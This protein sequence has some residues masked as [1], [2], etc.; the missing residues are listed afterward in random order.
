MF[1]V[2]VKDYGKV[3]AQPGE[4]YENLIRQM[5]LANKPKVLAVRCSNVLRELNDTIEQPCDLTLVDLA[6]SDGEKIYQRSLSFIM[7]Y[8][9]K[10]CFPNIKVR[11]EHSLSKGLYCEFD[12]ERK[13]LQADYD[14]IR[15]K[16]REAIEADLPFEKMTVR[17]EEAIAIFEKRQ[18]P[19]KVALLKYRDNDWINLYKLED[20][21]DYFYGYMVPST[22]YIQHFEIVKYDEGIILMH[23]TKYHPFGVAPFEES[24]M[25]AEVFK[26]S[27]AWGEIMNI[28]YVCNLNALIESGEHKELMQIAEALHEKK[29]ATIADIITKRRKRVI[30]IAGPSSSGKTTFANRLRLQLKVNGLHPITISTDNYFVDRELTPRDENGDLDFESLEAVDVDLFNKHIMQLLDGESVD[31]PIFD[32]HTG[33]RTYRQKPICINAQQ[34]IIIEGIHGLNE[35]LSYHIYKRDKFKIYVS[36]LTQLNIDEHNRIPTTQTRLLRRIVRDNQFRGHSA[37]KTINMW[38]SVRRGE[39]KNI[40]PFQEE[41]DIMFNTALPYELAIL[42]KHAEPL[43]AQIPQSEPAYVEALLLM[44]FLSYFKS[45]EDDQLVPYVSILKEFIGGSGF[46]V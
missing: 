5:A 18:M 32:F 4:R 31:L 9:A 41:A 46:D 37:L 36:A 6:S 33:K 23:P 30:L 26:E 15:L 2:N 34:P 10:V 27:E 11:I 35:K 25:I 19:T 17:K 43:L 29:V 22:G 13:L 3:S 1:E 28:G 7:I 8:A 24:P 40:F 45:I 12:Y 16:M 21:I 42:K 39:E 14:R 20:Q 38:N 44:K